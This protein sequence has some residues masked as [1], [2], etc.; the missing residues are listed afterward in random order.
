LLMQEIGE[1]FTD[2]RMIVDQKNL[3]LHELTGV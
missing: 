2:Q 1:P 3:M